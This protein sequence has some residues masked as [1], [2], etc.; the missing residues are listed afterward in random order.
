MNYCL[1]LFAIALLFS[2]CLSV[3]VA[4]SPNW[5]STPAEAVPADKADFACASKP[6]DLTSKQLE[7]LAIAEFEKRGGRMGQSQYEVKIRLKGCDWLVGIIRLPAAPGS[8]FGVLVDG[9]T[10]KVKDYMGG[11]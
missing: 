2:V 3:A 5:S 8:H 4:T 10:G 7:Q 11:S 9:L 6:L 1:R